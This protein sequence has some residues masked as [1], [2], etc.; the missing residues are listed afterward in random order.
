MQK[1][2]AWLGVC[3]DDCGHVIVKTDDGKKSLVPAVQY[4]VKGFEPPIYELP[5]RD[6][7][8]AAGS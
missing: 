2:L 8:S 6:K 4:V 7:P 3:A 1:G 5:T